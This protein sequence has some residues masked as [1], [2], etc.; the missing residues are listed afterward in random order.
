MNHVVLTA[1]LAEFK[2]LR[3]TP[4]GLPAL[5]MVL[6]HESSLEQAGQIRQVKLVVK[7]IAFGTIAERIQQQSL[8]SNWQF[9]GFLASPRLGKNP[10]LHIQ[11]FQPD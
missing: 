7:A 2:N 9:T 11:E 3:Y 8:G 5:D 4:A 6:E 10:V 1:C